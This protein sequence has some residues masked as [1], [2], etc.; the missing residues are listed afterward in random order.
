MAERQSP[1]AA[2]PDAT[3]GDRLRAGTK[4]EVQTSFDGSWNRG[5]EVEEPLERGYRI[6]RVAD[7]HVLPTVFASEVVRRDR[8]RDTW[9]F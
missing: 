2:R 4:V 9:W 6:R 8:H 5:F 7:D 1:S 3:P